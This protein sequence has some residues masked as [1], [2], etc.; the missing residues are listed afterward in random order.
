[1]GWK[2]KTVVFLTLAVFLATCLWM[3]YAVHARYQGNEY[4]L[5]L[6]AAFNAASLLNG[7]E[8]FTD[9]DKAVIS[10]YDGQR[11]VIL[12]ENYKAIASLLRKDHAM[13]LFD[14]VKAD[15]PLS[16]AI[17]DCT[18]IRIEPDGD[19]GALVFLGTDG[20]RSFT[21]HVRGGNIWKMILEYTTTGH[22]ENRNIPLGAA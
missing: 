5:Q 12:P 15:A 18:R 4:V 1:M 2:S 9:P 19:D 17:C 8:T 21:M 22:M 6:G 11:Y 20:G 16:I 10:T 7:E 14:R 13:P 3:G